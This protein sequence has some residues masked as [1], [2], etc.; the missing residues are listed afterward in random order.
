MVRVAARALG[1]RLVLITDR[2]DLP[3]RTR[4]LGAR[5]AR[6]RGATASRGGAP[7]ARLAGSSLGLDEAI[8]NARRFAGIELADAVAACTLRPARLLGLESERGTLRRGARA[9][10]AVLDAERAVAETWLA[11]ELVWAATA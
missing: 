4:A 2:I 3:G 10:L 11:G 7:T 5:R 1:E 9:D 6:A 8:R